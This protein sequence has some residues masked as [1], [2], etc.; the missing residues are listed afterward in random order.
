[1]AYRDDFRVKYDA[2]LAGI[3]ALSKKARRAMTF[4]LVEIVREVS[5]EWSYA[6]DK[7]DATNKS[8][9]NEFCL[10]AAGTLLKI[11]GIINSNY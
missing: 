1:M 7:E 10:W 2:E 4:R 5:F 6:L 9:I 11:K 8:E 3:K